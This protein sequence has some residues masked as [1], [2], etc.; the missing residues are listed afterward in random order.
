PSSAVEA[1]P[2]VESL[3]SPP[4]LAPTFNLTY[5]LSQFAIYFQVNAFDFYF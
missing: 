2:Y 1:D 3:G 5:E 4:W